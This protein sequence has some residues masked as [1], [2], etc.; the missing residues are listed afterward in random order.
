MD[1]FNPDMLE[2]ARESRGYT[3]KA[4]SELSGVDQ[5]N[6]S[7][8]ERGNLSISE[9]AM[10]KLALALRYPLSF[11]ARTDEVRGIGS[12]CFYHRKRQSMPL[13]EL[14]SI[15]A[16]VNVL[17]MQV[18][19]LLKGAEVECDNRIARLDIGD[20]ETPEQIARLVRAIW[21]LPVGPVRN[22]V[23]AIEMAGG[24]V[25]RCSF[26]TTKL[27]A[28]SQWCRGMPPLLFVNADIPGDRARW[29]L[30]H[31][32][33]HL[34][35]HRI[36]SPDS[37][38]EADLFASE[39]L[40]PAR[41]IMA[42]LNGMSLHRAAALKPY[43]RVSMAALI[44]RAHAVGKLTDSQKAQLFKQLSAS[45]YRT[46]EPDTVP[47]ETP[48]VVRGI[49]GMYITTLDH[50]TPDLAR[51]VDLEEE[52]FASLY[53]AGDADRRGFRVVG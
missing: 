13:G 35:M 36:P 27:D 15:Q 47:V 4:L 39:F 43:W 34:I 32:L 11:F 17:R 48:T 46:K 49:V 53:L 5:G 42:D 1:R 44:M 21:D 25:F 37:E 50:T 41:D 2:L 28:I 45:G 12:G 19:R 16:K 52:E 29:T 22:L 30:A 20:G 51:L 24:I 6:I 8:Y 23:S 31:E 3:Q 10:E 14:K 9:A 26:G 40:M 33:G 38:R 7:K 18:A